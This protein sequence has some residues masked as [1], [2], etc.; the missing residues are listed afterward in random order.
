MIHNL[1]L[2]P[3]ILNQYLAE[4]RDESVQGDRLR[5]RTNLQRIGQIMGYEISKQLSYSSCEISTPLGVAEVAMPHQDIVLVSILRAG[6]PMHQGL[7]DTFDHA[8]N[9]FVSA[10]RS[11]HKDGTFEI[12]LQ[13]VTCPD[14]QGKTLMLCDPMLATGASL[15]AT[16]EA[17]QDYGKYSALHIAT[18]IASRQGTDY[19]HRLY[20]E[21]HIWAGAIDEELTGKSYIV[22][23]L[24]DAGDLAFGSKLQD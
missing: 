21:A 3:S 18:A 4:I 19:I 23:G 15:H 13:Y 16:L 22:P 9:A 6:L 8:D 2:S 11:H 24:G 1:S 7:L 20:P 12:K 10:Y 17:L 5:F 14:L